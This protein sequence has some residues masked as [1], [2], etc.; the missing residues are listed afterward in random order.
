[1]VSKKGEPV[2]RNRGFD[3]PNSSSVETW[4][5]SVTLIDHDV[6]ITG[7]DAEEAPKEATKRKWIQSNES[8]VMGAVRRLTAGS[9]RPSK[10]LCV[11]LPTS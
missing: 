7:S 6:V 9:G 5:P 4:T 1:M 11:T 2:E 10:P 8:A 3:I